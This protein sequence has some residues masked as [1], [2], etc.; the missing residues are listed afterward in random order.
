MSVS[1]FVDDALLSAA[2]VALVR[3]EALVR[4]YPSRGGEADMGFPHWLMIG[5]A[6][7]VVVGWV[8]TALQ[9]DVRY[10]IHLAWSR[11]PQPMN[12]R[13]ESREWHE[14]YLTPPT[15]SRDLRRR[16]HAGLLTAAAMHVNSA[17]RATQTATRLSLSVRAI[18]PL[19]IS[20]L[21]P[22]LCWGRYDTDSASLR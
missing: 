20:N 5:G 14:F 18:V 19:E 17:S 11:L 15:L 10:P 3:L 7:L 4:L 1:H 2:P 22:A 9:K 21:M 6:L 12:K 13:F 8:G 16:S